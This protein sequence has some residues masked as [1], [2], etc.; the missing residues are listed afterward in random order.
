MPIRDFIV[1]L[2]VIGAVPLILVRPHIGI[3]VWS[4][5]AYMQPQRLAWGFAKT[6]H[7]SDIVGVAAL[8]AWLFSP[9]PKRIPWHPVSVILLIFTAWTCLTTVF[10]L[11]PE[12]AYGK[13]EQAMKIMLMAFVTM[14]VMQS[15]ERLHALV[16]VIVVSIGFYGIKGGIFS[17]L[18]GGE[19]L[20]YG[21]GR[22]FIGANN[23][24]ALA[25][26]MVLPLM[27][28]L[29]LHTAQPLVRYGLI[30]AMLLSLTAIAA[31]YSRGA[32][33]AGVAMLLYLWLKSRRKVLVSMLLVGAV[34]VGLVFMP[35]KWLDRVETI[36]NYEQDGAVQGRFQ[37]WRF[38]YNLALER[39]IVGGGFAVEYDE[40]LFLRYSPDAFRARSFHSNYFEV[41]GQHGFVGLVLYLMLGVA[42]LLCGTRII[43]RT[44][45]SA[46]L[47]WARDL[48]AM[49]Q[50]SIIGYAVGGLFLNKAF[51][52][53]FYSLVAIMVLTDLLVARAIA[54]AP[55]PQEMRQRV[56][57]VSGVGSYRAQS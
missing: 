14:M 24:L 23:A 8:V 48:A 47:A 25:L 6:A 1:T 52:D 18:T 3:L 35:P 28:Y 56:P 33:V 12:F 29:Q 2:I 51:F 40:R 7:L 10:A 30:A 16:W 26:I 55:A 53:L 15:R 9:E 41:L 38:A 39:P 54:E 37:A 42:S 13:W 50:V 31:S 57:V 11:V 43:R 4:W 32:V 22:S 36:Q 46:D 19:H 45:G 49:T 34:G 5:L 21:P 27:G 20:V 17:I 44:R